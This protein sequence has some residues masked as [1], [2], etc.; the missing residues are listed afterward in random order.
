MQPNATVS[1]VKVPKTNFE[2]PTTGTA[3]I[4]N[5]IFSE[6]GQA[7]LFV[8]VIS[9]NESTR[10]NTSLTFPVANKQLSLLIC[11]IP[12]N[13][14]NSIIKL[15]VNQNFTIQMNIIDKQSG[16]P[17]ERINWR[18]LIW[19]FTG[20]ICPNSRKPKNIPINS[21]SS[22]VYDL[23]K[24]NNNFTW[25]INGFQLSWVYTYCI[26]A[27]A[28]LN[29]SITRQLQYDLPI[30]KF[31]IYVNP[32]NYTEPTEKV[33]KPFRFKVT[34]SYENMLLYVD[35][36]KA[37]I[38]SELLM[39][40]PNILFENITLSKG[41]I[42]VDLIA[43]SDTITVIQN[44]LTSF[45]SSLNDGS[46]TFS[47]GGVDYTATNDKTNAGCRSTGFLT[48]LITTLLNLLIYKLLPR[49]YLL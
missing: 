36:F 6:S 48:S 32:E 25:T 4:S 33:M 31:R 19:K 28:Y 14:D 20:D 16:A 13:S 24:T 12:S 21:S 39:R 29:D 17:V 9:P 40:Y 23:S 18:N 44:A 34:G 27:N 41:S 8:S 38:Q 37:A 22:L 10:L 1:P 45:T 43:A 15:S 35:E 5:L 42:T 47:V 30:T 2:D 49:I 7:D 46:V 26:S 11:P 3:L